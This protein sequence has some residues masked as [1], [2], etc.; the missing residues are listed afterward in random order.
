MGEGQKSNFRIESVEHVERSM[1]KEM[2]DKEKINFLATQETKLEI[3][4]D[5]L[6]I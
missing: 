5:Y 1:I 6:L 4:L 2:V 3:V